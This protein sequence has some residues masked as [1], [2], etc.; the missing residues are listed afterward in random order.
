MNVLFVG[1]GLFSLKLIL[2]KITKITEI[3]N[4]LYIYGNVL[5]WNLFSMM[6]IGPTKFNIVF[7]EHVNGIYDIFIVS[8][9]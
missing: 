1:F 7:N 4:D 9:Y 5:V 8:N 3:R 2:V 6:K